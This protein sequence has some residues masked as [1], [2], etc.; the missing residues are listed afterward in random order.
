M[1]TDILGDNAPVSNEDASTDTSTNVAPIIDASVPAEGTSWLPEGYRDNASFKDFKSM[2]GLCKSY[3]HLKSEVGRS[4]RIPGP[5]AGKEDLDKF[6]VKL[7]TVK[8]VMRSPDTDNA[9]AMS[10]FYNSQGRPEEVSGYNIDLGEN[11]GKVD[12]S[13]LDSFKK[14]AHEAGLTTT[15]AKKMIEFDVARMNQQSDSD[16]HAASNAV[17]VLKNRWGDEY[18]NRVAGAKAAYRTYKSQFPEGFAELERTSKNNPALVAILS[19][20]GKT[21]QEK[22]YI[23]A[24]L[25]YGGNTPDEALE[26]ISEIRNNKEHAYH[27]SSHPDNKMARDKMRRLYKAAYPDRQA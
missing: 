18:N 13:V 14:I 20:I 8:G 27:K 16:V 23:D 9:E 6:Y 2:D 17:S 11:N 19:D 3:E 10:Q 5:D 22:G 7:T 25:A 15:Q 24:P 1:S 12:S 4:I 21:M 26:A